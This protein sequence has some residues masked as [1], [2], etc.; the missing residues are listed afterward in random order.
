MSFLH[1]CHHGLEGGGI[2]CVWEGLRNR[3][4]VL[5][6]RTTSFRCWVDLSQGLMSSLPP[7]ETARLDS[8]FVPCHNFR[9]PWKQCCWIRPYSALCMEMPPSHPPQ[10]CSSFDHLFSILQ[11]PSLFSSEL[12]SPACKQALKAPIL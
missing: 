1:L 4:Q 2:K 11:H 9:L 12:F 7:V 10:L 6:V 8:T 5:T 3:V